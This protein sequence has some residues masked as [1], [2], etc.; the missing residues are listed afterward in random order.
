[1]RCYDLYNTLNVDVIPVHDQDYV[2]LGDN[3]TAK[4]M[5]MDAWTQVGNG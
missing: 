5:D 1:M 2:R 3:G 4:D